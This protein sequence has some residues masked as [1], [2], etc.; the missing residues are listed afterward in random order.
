M[1]PNKLA[2]KIWESIRCICAS[3]RISATET[4][5]FQPLLG[6]FWLLK[7]VNNKIVHSESEI[8]RAL[9]VRAN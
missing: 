6:E 4:D 5:K 8:T 1:L 7:I 3:I 2:E 9:T